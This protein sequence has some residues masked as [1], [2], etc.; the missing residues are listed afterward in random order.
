MMR[1]W[2]ATQLRRLKELEASERER[3]LAFETDSERDGA[4]QNLAAGLIRRQRRRLR[5]LRSIVSRPR[6]CELERRLADMLTECGFVQ[7]TTPIIMSRSDLAKMSITADH[8]LYRQ[9]YWIDRKLGLRPMLAPHLYRLLQNLLRVWEKPVRLFEIGPCFRRESGGAQHT[10]E[11]TMLNLVE[12]GIPLQD[13]ELR[14]QELAARVATEAGLA[15][16]RIAAAN[17]EVYGETIDVL[18]G[19]RNME[20]GSGAMGPHA[21]DKAWRITD[22]WVGIGFG[23]ERMLMAAENVESLSRLGRSLS[24]L[25]GIRLNI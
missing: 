17:S 6:L 11:F 20:V 3:T 23:L 15:D 12:A 24:Y 1:T 25:D 18:A 13:R 9:V 21:L 4:F 14:L 19:R 8:P 5:E 7:V 16:H 22:T 2:S 10:R